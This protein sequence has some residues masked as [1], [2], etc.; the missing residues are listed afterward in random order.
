MG[1]WTV[2][3]VIPWLFIPLVFDNKQTED[4]GESGLA[5]APMVLVTPGVGWGQT[6]WAVPVKARSQQLQKKRCLWMAPSYLQVGSA[7]PSIEVGLFLNSVPTTLFGSSG[8][9]FAPKHPQWS[10]GGAWGVG[11]SVVKSILIPINK[12]DCSI[13]SACDCLKIPTSHEVYWIPSILQ[14]MD[15]I[16]PL[17]RMAVGNKRQ[18]HR[19]DGG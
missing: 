8:I 14:H 17:D 13:F 2:L 15:K 18:A 4:F 1:R 3:Y 19:I 10:G 5:S 7:N 16:Q 11:E 6:C 12:Q 9:L